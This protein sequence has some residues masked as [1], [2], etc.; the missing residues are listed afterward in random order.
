M[1]APPDE[2]VVIA[3]AE[4][5]TER[6]H[7]LSETITSDGAVAEF[8]IP[9]TLVGRYGGDAAVEASR[10]D[11]MIELGWLVRKGPPPSIHGEATP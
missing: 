9:C 7:P 5:C 2:N 4:V 1:N 8:C 6:D 11:E 10:A 3:P